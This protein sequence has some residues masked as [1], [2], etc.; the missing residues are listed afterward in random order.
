[1]MRRV[2][3][4]GGTGF[5][6]RRLV[7]HL[8][9]LHLS[10]ICL[11]GPAGADD[12]AVLADQ[13]R[14]GAQIIRADLDTAPITTERPPEQV[15]TIFHL[16]ANTDTDAT[17]AAVRVNDLGTVRLLD[18]L[19][20]SARGSRLMFTSTVAVS[21]PVGV[22]ARPA[23]ETEVCHPRTAYGRT[24]LDAERLIRD[25]AP[26]AGYTYTILRLP[27]VYGPGQKPGG[28]FDQLADATARAAWLGR[29][30]WPGRTSVVYVDDVVRL[31]VD[32]STMPE[33][34][35]QTFCVATGEVSTVGDVARAIGTATSHP[36]S[37]IR[38]PAGA[39]RLAR[40]AA[41]SP[42]VARLTP[43]RAQLALW[44]F[45]LI[46]G[47]GFFQSGAKLEAAYRRPLRPL[48]TGLRE[49]ATEID[50]HRPTTTSAIATD[51]LLPDVRVR[52]I[53]VKS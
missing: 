43:A 15:D 25:R 6:G 51:P 18:W 50:R 8:C 44:R 7:S 23:D 22:R 4:T 26:D 5:I 19:G 37:P 31:L 40:W 12:A 2:L 29:V 45:G 36:V 28:L 13:Q 10:V 49:M 52:P 32:L 35:D 20:E 34:A 27:T 16:A 1:M 11:A 41:K 9:G 47:D 38:L 33:A 48:A 17:D 21:D 42:L 3:V 24:K 46:V 53:K 30:D 39:W 14:R